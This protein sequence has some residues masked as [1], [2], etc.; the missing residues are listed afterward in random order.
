MRAA[1]IGAAPLS[2]RGVEKLR[3]HTWVCHENTRKNYNCHD[4]HFNASGNAFGVWP[5]VWAVAVPVHTVGGGYGS[6]VRLGVLRASRVY[7]ALH[8][9]IDAGLWVGQ[10]AGPLSRAVAVQ[11][12]IRS[13]IG[14]EGEAMDTEKEQE[15]RHWKRFLEFATTSMIGISTE[16]E[17]AQFVDWVKEMVEEPRPFR[18]LLLFFEEGNSPERVN[19]F[20]A[21]AAVQLP[22]D[23]AIE[24][25]PDVPSPEIAKMVKLAREIN[26]E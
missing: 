4:P 21:S 14:S 5:G 10:H 15:A 26:G 12:Q 3:P 9:A 19:A 25:V 8:D 6:S 1:A 16:L 2:R 13:E 22:H 11:T 18:K 7:G 17:I 23:T 24:V 20:R